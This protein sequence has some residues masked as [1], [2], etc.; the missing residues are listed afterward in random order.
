[1]KK[2]CL[3]LLTCL[4]GFFLFAQ[5]ETRG[6]G[7]SP[8]A[9]GMLPGVVLRAVVVGISDYQDPKIRDLHYA[10]KDALAFA[11]YLRLPAVA[12]LPEDKL[13]LL[14]NEKATMGGIQSAL[15]WLLRSSKK[16]DQA[17]IYISSHG[18]V[19]TKNAQEKGYL[20]AYDTPKNN[21]RLNAIDI[22]YLN[23]HVIG[24]L[25]RL[26]VK[27]IIILDACHS[28]T[29]AGDVVDG[30]EATATELMNRFANEVRIMSCQPYELSLEG[31]KW[32]NGR[33]LFSYY[34]IDGLKGRAD[35]DGNKRVDLYELESFLQRRVREASAKTQHPDIFGGRKKEALFSMDEATLAEVLS[36]AQG[37]IQKDFESDLLHKLAFTKGYANYDKFDGAI[38]AGRLLGPDSSAA[39]FYQALYA[40]SNFVPLRSMLSERLTTALLDSAQQAI[41]AYL[42][43]DPGELVDRDRFNQ[44]YT[45]FAGYLREAA[46]LLGPQDWRYRQ[47][48][49]KQYYFEGLALRL[50]SEQ[51]GRSDKLYRAALEKQMKALE[52]EDRAAFIHNE[53][54]LLQL[55]LGESE[56]GISALLQ[57][58]ALSPTWA[59][60]YNNLAT[61]MRRRD[62]LDQAVHYYRRALA[63]KPDLASA[64]TNLGNVLTDL[65][66]NDSAELM[67]RKAIELNPSDKSNHFKL[68]LLLSGLPSR[69][70]EAEL[71]FQR[72]LQ[73]DPTYPEAYFELGN[74]YDSLAQPAKAKEYYEQAIEMNPAYAEAYLN[75]GIHDYF[76]GAPG[77]AEKMLLQAIRYDSSLVA[78]YASL[79]KIQEPDVEKTAAMLRTAPLDRAIKAQILR[80][81]GRDLLQTR[82]APD[83]ATKAFLLATEFDPNDAW[84]HYLLCTAYALS[85]QEREALDSLEKC[86]EKAGASAG[87]YYEQ[88]QSDKN[89]NALRESKRYLKILQHYFPDKK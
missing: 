15:E 51:L 88:I 43:A 63:L 29:L 5:R 61:E 8:S 82:S 81:T 38:K 13:K 47:T 18:D 56:K 72:T 66:K 9:S 70:K 86:L 69:L 37:D 32:G 34:F 20:L 6:A 11:N 1:M 78:A 46:E 65:E 44:K 4:A 73:M 68:G 62:S 71:L 76:N 45:R 17:V 52:Q 10:D 12:N 53:I 35:E 54:G 3:L 31:V 85:G 74:L 49:A 40:D 50:E 58:I 23:D 7:V 16:G 41:A 60:P 48:L 83:H 27:V 2:N 30:K 42:N 59:I 21:Y 19:E 36:R 25:Y 67:Y 75:L 84:N 33:G 79:A 39:N 14:T 26:G 80:I 55:E 77:E 28:G 64:Y 87:D 24:G 57:A 22:E 89:L